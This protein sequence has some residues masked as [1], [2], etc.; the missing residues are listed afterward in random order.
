MIHRR[1]QLSASRLSVR[2]RLLMLFRS[3]MPTFA[4]FLSPR[5]TNI[6]RITHSLDIQLNIGNIFREIVNLSRQTFQTHC[7]TTHPLT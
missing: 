4:G 1:A 5:P 3:K 6:Q 2:R 7:K